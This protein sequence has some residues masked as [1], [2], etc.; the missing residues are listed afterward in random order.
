MAVPRPNS[1][2]KTSE[3][4]VALCNIQAVSLNSKKNVLSPARILSL[5][6]ILVNILSTGVSLQLSAGT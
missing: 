1:S 5:A 2:I 6:P 4:F 3:F